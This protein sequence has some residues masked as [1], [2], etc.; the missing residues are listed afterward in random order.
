MEAQ[1]QTD[2]RF[3]QNHYMLRKKALKLFGGSFTFYDPS[4]QVAFYADMKAFKLK[5]DIRIYSDTN[6]QLELLAIKARNIIDWAS[7][8]YDVFDSATNTLIGS[9]KRRGLA[10]AFVR[11]EWVLLDTAGIE[12]GLIQEDS[13]V[14]GMLRRWIPFMAL[15]PQSYSVFVNN[16]EVADFKQQFNPFILKIDLDFSKDQTSRFDRRL[17]IAAALLMS[18]I[19][20]KQE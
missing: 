14:M 2:P 6:K 4:G 15:I 11:D 20:G 18:A 19:E 17:G 8:T 13:I 16:I 12:Y 3:S 9:F 7:G 1:M 5:E 10:S